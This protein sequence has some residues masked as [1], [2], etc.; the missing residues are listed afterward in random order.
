[1]EQL[2]SGFLELT[3]G[4]LVETDP[5]EPDHGVQPFIDVE[6]FQTADRLTT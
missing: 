6:G 5:A 1:M 3:S 2:T 4:S